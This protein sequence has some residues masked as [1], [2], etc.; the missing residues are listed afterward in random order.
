VESIG[1]HGDVVLA[2]G[3]LGEEFEEEFIFNEALFVQCVHDVV[4]GVIIGDG[5]GDK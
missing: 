4:K 2:V 3:E 5:D 1:A